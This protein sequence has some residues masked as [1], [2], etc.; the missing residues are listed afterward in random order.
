VSEERLHR[1]QRSSY[2]IQQCRV[3]VPQSVPADLRNL[4]LFAYRIELPIPK[5][6]STKGSTL[7]RPENKSLGSFQACF[8]TGQDQK[9]AGTQRNRSGAGPRLGLIEMPLVER[10]T[11]AKQSGIKIYVLPA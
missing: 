3:R 11:Y 10:S 8:E 4:Q 6:S 7:A 1:A 5:I 2:R 9:P